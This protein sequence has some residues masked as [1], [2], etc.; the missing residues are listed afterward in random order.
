MWTALEAII[1][2]H[3]WTPL[4]LFVLL[5]VLGFIGIMVVDVIVDLLATRR[6]RI[7]RRRRSIQRL[8][9]GP[10]Y[11]DPGRMH[12]ETAREVDRL[13]ARVPAP[14]SPVPLAGPA[15]RAGGVSRSRPAA[16][17]VAPGA[18]RAAGYGTGTS[19]V[20]PG[21]ADPKKRRN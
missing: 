14:H 13:D 6:L 9:G 10:T 16:T 4:E 5:L 17:R 8:S 18:G 7:W 1:R 12:R 2:A 11:A 15:A 21:H 3:H 19:L 20:F